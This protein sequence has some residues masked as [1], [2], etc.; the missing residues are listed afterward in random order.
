MGNMHTIME[1]NRTK[2]TF[3]YFLIFFQFFIK[4]NYRICTKSFSAKEHVGRNVHAKFGWNLSSGF[5]GNA[6]TRNIR[7]RT[8]DCGLRTAACGFARTQS[9]LAHTLH[10]WAKYMYQAW[11]FIWAANEENVVFKFTLA[12]WTEGIYFVF[13]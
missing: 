13:S 12:H 6:S 1:I 9:H 10:V 11:K 3:C 8:A 2:G 5:S 7:P 4:N